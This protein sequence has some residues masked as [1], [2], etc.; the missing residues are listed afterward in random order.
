MGEG[1]RSSAETQA[2]N[3]SGGQ[4]E[5]RGGTA[6][7]LG[8]GEG[9]EEEVAAIPAPFPRGRLLYLWLGGRSS[10]LSSPSAIKLST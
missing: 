5:N 6:G 2:H 9:G 10:H 8:E 1:E 7:T 3:I 4:K